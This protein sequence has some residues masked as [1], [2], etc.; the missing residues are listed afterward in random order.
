MIS[1][2][3]N[4][5]E[6]MPSHE[7]VL[8]NSPAVRPNL[9]EFEIVN[10]TSPAPRARSSTSSGSVPSKL[11]KWYSQSSFKTIAFSALSVIVLALDASFLF[12][13]KINGDVALSFAGTVLA[14]S[15]PSPFD[16][17]SKKKVIE[18]AQNTE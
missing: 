4:H 15:L 9:S 8:P 13:G 6:R 17:K 14:Y 18:Q 7:P 3:T 5:I 10:E 11:K 2:D 16:S 1:E 12:A